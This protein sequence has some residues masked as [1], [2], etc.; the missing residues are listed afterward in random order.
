MYFDTHCHL[1]LC[2]E[3]ISIDDHVKEALDKK[4]LKILDPGISPSDF[5]ERRKKLEKHSNV[6]LSCAIAPHISD[7][8][9][10]SALDELEKILD[11]ENVAAI[12]EIGLE[13]FH[14]KENHKWQ[15]EL[16][17]SQLEIAK[18]RDLAVFLHVRDGYD[19]LVEVLKGVGHTKGAIHC[20]TGNAQNA[21]EVL[22]FGFYLS[23]SGILTFKNAKDIQEAFLNCPLD[24]VLSETDAPYLAPTPHRGKPNKSPYMLETIKMMAQIKSVDESV[25]REQLWTNSHDLLGLVDD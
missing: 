5:V 8:V 3:N 19:D 13:Y 22:D 23:F 18:A 24:R 16:L 9:D 12:G 10:K 4:I 20:F 25:I 17:A 14:L 6:L 15:K 2:E 21:K 11:T 7:K 1:T